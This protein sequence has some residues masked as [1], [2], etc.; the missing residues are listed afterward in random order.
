MTF[1]QERVRELFNAARELPSTDREPYLDS[2]CGDDDA[3][4]AEVESLLVHKFA[5]DKTVRPGSQ[6]SKLTYEDQPG[7]KIGHFKLLNVLG[8]G[9]QGVVFLAEQSK[10]VHRRVA[11]K[12]IKAGMDTK[13]VIARFEAERQAL[14][15]MNHPGIAQVYEVGATELGRPY[16]V[17][18]YVK[19]IQITDACDEQKLDTTQRLE[20][21][22]KVCEAVQHAH[23][24][25]IIHRDLKPSN[26]LVSIGQNDTPEPK[27]IDFGVAKATSQQLTEKTLVTQVGHFVGTPAYMSP[28]QADLKATD[29]DTRSDVYALGVILYELLTGMPPFDPDVLRDA[30]LEKMR[31][32]IRTQPPPKPSTQLSSIHDADDATKI[33]EVRQTQIAKLAGLLRKELEWI[34]LKALRKRRSERYDS[35]KSM[36]DDIRRYLTGVPLEAGSESVLYRLNKTLLRNKGLF[37]AIAA[38]V[39]SMVVGITVA[40]IGWTEAR[41]Q[42]EATVSSLHLLLMESEDTLNPSRETKKELY[43]DR[44]NRLE[45][46]RI[47]LGDLPALLRAIGLTNQ[48]IGRWYKTSPSFTEV[49]FDKALAHYLVGLNI[50]VGLDE[51]PQDTAEALI[52]IGDLH[53]QMNNFSE[54]LESYEKALPYLQ[55]DVD[56]SKQWLAKAKMNI[57]DVYLKLDRSDEALVLAMEFVSDSRANLV[58]SPGNSS[59]QRSLANRLQRLARVYSKTSSGKL[60]IDSQREA[61]DLYIVILK[62]EPPFVYVK[63]VAWANYFLAEYLFS[64]GQQTEGHICL[65]TGLDILRSWVVNN[66]EL[67]Y[68][69]ND[70]SRYSEAYNNLKSSESDDYG[71]AD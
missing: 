51:Y 49:T 59:M 66:P 27:I 10:P 18:E 47:Y 58:D 5:S 67:P 19:G 35:A 65:D 30:G 28:E 55:S 24:K 38:V 8:E 15:I 63:D 4:R 6:S 45:D 42:R 2:E 26:I 48:H 37:V 52:R 29:I 7:D 62:K 53:K 3:L 20:L 1:D 56:K 13:Q 61:L 71:S 36:G 9:G 68:A 70:L 12:V 39:L 31:E 57:F 14:A 50:A 54:A 69:S 60:A 11:L 25:G 21:F 17:M 22:A 64:D 40:I 32:I 43:R 16:F 44:L 41:I 33:A 23:M 46:L 34:P